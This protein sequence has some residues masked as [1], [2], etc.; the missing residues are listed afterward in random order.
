LPQQ[1]RHGRAVGPAM[2]RMCMMSAN[3]QIGTL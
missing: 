1:P 2:T 3:W